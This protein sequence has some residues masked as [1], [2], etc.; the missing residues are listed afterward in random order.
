VGQQLLFVLFS[1][2]K[3][4]LLFFDGLSASIVGV[5][6]AKSVASGLI[7]AGKRV[8]FQSSPAE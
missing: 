7:M 2:V 6:G 5:M 1:I 4:F 8:V 3:V